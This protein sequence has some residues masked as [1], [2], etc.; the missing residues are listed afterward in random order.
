MAHN[1]S[2]EGKDF[3]SSGHIDHEAPKTT[4]L[5]EALGQKSQPSP[6]SSSGHE[7]ARLDAGASERPETKK[8]STNEQ[9]N[10]SSEARTP[11]RQ[12]ETIKRRSQRF[13]MDKEDVVTVKYFPITLTQEAGFDD[14]Q[15]QQQQRSQRPESHR[16]GEHGTNEEAACPP[17]HTYW[18]NG[19][20]RQQELLEEVSERYFWRDKGSR[21]A[22]T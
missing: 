12:F 7:N 3:V 4:D 11:P 10:G 17:E 13:E 20:V 8:S 19:R 21:Q 18:P 6:A 5:D 16:M 9:D 1:L 2:G 15:Q 14:Q 22:M